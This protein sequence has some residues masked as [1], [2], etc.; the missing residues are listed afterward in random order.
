[1][2]RGYQRRLVMIRTKESRIFESAF[3]ILRS[4]TAQIAQCEMVDEARRIIEECGMPRKKAV[5]LTFGHIL[6]SSGICFFL[7]AAVV[8]AVWIMRAL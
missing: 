7:G 6:L 4:G 3:F 2:L 5:R 8:G 1:M